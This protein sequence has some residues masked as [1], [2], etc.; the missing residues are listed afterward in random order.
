MPSAERRASTTRTGAL[1]ELTPAMAVLPTLPIDKTE[2]VGLTS[3][4]A[5]DLLATEGENRLPAA[6]Q[7][8]IVLKFASQLVHFFALML[9]V[10]GGLALLAGM[11]QLGVAIFVVVIVNGAFA[12]AQEFRAERAAA[13]L[14]DLLPKRSVVIRDGTR[15]DV[16]AFGLVVG[17]LVVLRAGDMISADLEV[18]S[19]EA[20]RVDA[21]MLTGESAPQDVTATGLL[22]A[23]CFVIGGEGTALVV[24]TGAH[25][26]LASIASLTQ[27]GERP[28][29]PLEHELTRVVRVIALIAVGV[30]ASFFGISVLVGGS[31]RNGFLFAVGVTVALVPE[32][33]LP[34]VTL[35]LAAGAQEM[36]KRH[37]LVRHL[38]S[39]ETLGST[40]YICTDKTGTITRNQ[41]SAVEVWTPLGTAQISGSGY[42]PTGVVD[43]DAT[44]LAAVAV[45]AR[46]AATCSDDGVVERDG[47]WVPDGDPT[48]AALVTLAKRCDA[49]AALRPARTREFPFDSTRRMMS[50]VV[51][52]ELLVKGAPESVLPQCGED[53]DATKAVEDA[54]RRGLRVLAVATRTI[55]DLPD[56]ATAAQIE[57]G[58]ALLGLI[59]IEDPPRAEVAEALAS[60]RA[61]GIKVAMLTGDNAETAA[62]IAR[63]VGLLGDDGIVLSGPELPTD[64]AVLGALIDRGGGVVISRVT[65]EDKL[66]IARAL[67]ARGHVVA[68]TG[69][70]V[71]DGPA[72]QAA[73]IGIAMG[74][75][76][77]DV[78]RA[79]SDLVLLDDNFA[80]IVK[81]V[82]LGRVTFSNMRRFLTYHL[83][84]NVAELTPFIIWAISGGRF[85][86]IL[87]V[88]QIL[89]FD[90]GADVLPALALG[91]E[92]MG[93]GSTNQ[94]LQGR[95]LIDQKVLTRVFAVLGPAESAMEVL[96]FLVVLAA[97]GWAPG[98]SFPKGHVLLT[99]SGTA[100]ATV[101]FCQIG[102]AFACRSATMW[103]GHL[104]WFSNRLL[105]AGVAVALVLLACFEFIGPVAAVLG[106][107]PPPA[108]GWLV[109]VCGVP[110]MLGVDLLHKHLRAHRKQSVASRS[111]QARFTVLPVLVDPVRDSA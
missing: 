23:G 27:Q 17:D 33:L 39:V 34:T 41:M 21:S 95:H 18:T 101:I 92:R 11:P 9:W 54:T 56:D 75:S 88:L 46:V 10:A 4:Q 40:T 65:P 87:G 74:E 81:A 107:A 66:D 76:G 52:G 69:D 49:T 91:V 63:K 5:R 67:Q 61:A 7:R 28:R 42:D 36:A 55:T 94:P 84:C 78:A 6:R 3:S 43:A 102:V 25:T 71:N 62:A 93:G 89:C 20:L 45:V 22:F 47:Q 70:G 50:V 80:T 99:A 58:L 72:L 26:R 59:A 15:Q 111:R 32:G 31:E 1:A 90:L 24:A 53:R 48:E 103:P 38:E 16:A 82:Q 97:S 13:R 79:A 60:S 106:Q 19:S 98:D 64:P 37:A 12:F 108:I 77:T 85:P 30:G 100:F 110:V 104:G 8:P 51:S 105:L 35:S 96:A 83:V 68:M 44:L 2:P 29:S 86:L 57:I 73:D 109:A 14:N